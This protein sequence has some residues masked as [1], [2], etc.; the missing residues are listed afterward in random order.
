M[1]IVLDTNCLLV[2]VKKYS[3]FYWLWQAFRNKKFVLCYTGE[4]LNEY[5]EVLSRYFSILVA[6]NTVEE[7]LFSPNTLP[8]TVYYNWQLITADPDDNKFVDCA[9]SANAN[10]IVSN[11]RH[12]NALKD[13]NFPKVNLLT[14]DEFRAV[15]QDKRIL[16]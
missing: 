5:Q 10:Y 16:D 11:D 4:I 1:K 8:V 12:F 6:K 2:A 13:I 15:I 7:I 3:D 9:I 14:I